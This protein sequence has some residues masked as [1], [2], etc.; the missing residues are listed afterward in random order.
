MA[1][2]GTSIAEKDDTET[3]CNAPSYGSGRSKGS[4][5][6][7]L[8]R[9]VRRVL[10]AIVCLFVILLAS[11]VLSGRWELLPILSG[12]MS[13]HMGTGSLAVAQREPTNRLRLGEIAVFHPPFSNQ[14][15]YVHRVVELTRS[16]G[17]VIVRTKGDANATPDPWTVSVAS[18]SIYVVR[19]SVPEAGYV[20]LWV[21]SKVGRA[22]ILTL[23]GLVSLGLV[24]SSV[25]P[26]R[27][28]IIKT[29]E[30]E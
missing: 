5:G 28:K 16:H 26:L 6:W 7:Q 20:I 19:F 27:R 18:P 4:W 13:P 29:T 22:A 11:A 23:A 17:K 2:T 10:A 15:V 9:M 14:V 8:F 12:S 21:H 1:A 3:G 25:W 24:I 30:P